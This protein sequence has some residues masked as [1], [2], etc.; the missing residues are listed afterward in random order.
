MNEKTWR[1]DQQA[2]QAGGGG[3]MEQWTA[4]SDPAESKEIGLVISKSLGNVLSGEE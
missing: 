1:L 3:G 2:K 4:V